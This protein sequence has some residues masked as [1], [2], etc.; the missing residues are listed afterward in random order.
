MFI[1]T[2]KATIFA[3]KERNMVPANISLRRSFRNFAMVHFL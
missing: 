3:P 1:A 2:A